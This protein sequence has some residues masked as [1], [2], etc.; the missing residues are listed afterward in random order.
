MA[1]KKPEVPTNPSKSLT[2][3]DTSDDND[4]N[5]G[6]RTSIEDR[7]YGTIPGSVIAIPIALSHSTAQVNPTLDRCSQHRKMKV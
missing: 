5:P 7:E 4:L 3:S 1:E 2:D 6:L